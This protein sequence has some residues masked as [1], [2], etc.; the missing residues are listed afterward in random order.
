MWAVSIIVA[1]ILLTVLWFYERT[2]DLGFRFWIMVMVPLTAIIE[3]GYWYGFRNAPNFLVGRYLMSFVTNGL[4]VVLAFWILREEVTV[5]KLLGLVL[6][7]L[8]LVLLK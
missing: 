1:S 5:T 6:I 2:T 7:V 3:L 4:G 8:G